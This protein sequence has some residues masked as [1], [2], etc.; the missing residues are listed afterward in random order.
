MAANDSARKSSR[1]K[2]T[3]EQVSIC[4]RL[5]PDIVEYRVEVKIGFEYEG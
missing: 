4:S 1:V 3:S 2:P 5:A